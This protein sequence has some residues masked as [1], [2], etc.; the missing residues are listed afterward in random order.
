[1]ENSDQ[2][3]FM[4]SHTLSK[5]ECNQMLLEQEASITIRQLCTYTDFAKA[6]VGDEGSPMTL[7]HEPGVV[8]GILSHINPSTAICTGNGYPEVFTRVA[9]YRAWILQ[10]MTLDRATFG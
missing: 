10:Q 6:C 5:G 9:P 1:M 2:L 4:V 7:F 8:I 3:I